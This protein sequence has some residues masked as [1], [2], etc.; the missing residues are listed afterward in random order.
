MNPL[1]RNALL[2]IGAFLT[3]CLVGARLH[4]KARRTRERHRLITP[5][6]AHVRITADD[7]TEREWAMEA[8][9]I[10]A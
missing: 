5:L 3:A 9:R 10:A 8:E 4:R 1:T 7:V 2:G 6:L